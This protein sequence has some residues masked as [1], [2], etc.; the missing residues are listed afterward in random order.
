M[1][2]V[3]TSGGVRIAA[4]TKVNR[5][6]YFLF[7]FSRSGVTIP[8]LVRKKITTGNSKTS[9]KANSSLTAKEK[10]CFTEGRAWI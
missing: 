4:A 5:M 3:I 7:F 9:P 1:H 6:A 10:Y 2:W 8:I